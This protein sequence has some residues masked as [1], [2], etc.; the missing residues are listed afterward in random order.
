MEYAELVDGGDAALYRWLNA[1][2]VYG[3]VVCCFGPAL[4]FLSFVFV[5]SCLCLFCFV[6]DCVCCAMCPGSAARWGAW[7]SG[8][9]TCVVRST[10]MYE[11]A[12]IVLRCQTLVCCFVLFVVTHFVL[13]RQQYSP[14][15]NNQQCLRSFRLT[16]TRQVWDVVSV[17]G[18]ENVAYT[19]LA[20]PPHQDL[21]Y[22]EA[23]PGLQLLHCLHFGAGVSGGDSSFADG[24]RI[25]QVVRERD[26]RA[27]ELLC[28]VPLTYQYLT[29]GTSLC[30]CMCVC[31]RA[32]VCVCACVC[33]CVRG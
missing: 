28:S 7:R 17:P 31:V 29:G 21:L 5:A 2:H 15:S 3:T 20:I 23:P 30:M 16:E 18:A 13:P 12:V 19:S 6:K 32:R 1:L 14:L 24:M 27:F 8:S 26:P 33:V 22:Y 9:R 4:V 11:E 10:A 25:G